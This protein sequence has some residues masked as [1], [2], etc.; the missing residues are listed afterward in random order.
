MMTAFVR[1]EKRVPVFAILPNLRKV[2]TD[3][4]RVVERVA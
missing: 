1:F 2:P 3:L 4:R